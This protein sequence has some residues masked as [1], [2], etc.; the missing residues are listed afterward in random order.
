[1]MIIM[2]LIAIMVMVAIVTTT[3]IVNSRNSSPT[4]INTNIHNDGGNSCIHTG[5]NNYG[6]TRGNTITSITRNKHNVRVLIF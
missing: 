3:V 6:S 1:M 2:V 5:F 4:T